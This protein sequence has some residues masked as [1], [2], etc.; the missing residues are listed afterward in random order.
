[1]LFEEFFTNAAS[2]MTLETTKNTVDR[3]PYIRPT[4][5]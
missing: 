5:C 3:D 1:M 4:G 2:L